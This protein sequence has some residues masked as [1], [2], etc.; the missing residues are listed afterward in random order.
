MHVKSLCLGLKRYGLIIIPRKL[1]LAIDS[2]RNYCVAFRSKY[3][4]EQNNVTN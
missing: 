2:P 1:L 4:T 3:A